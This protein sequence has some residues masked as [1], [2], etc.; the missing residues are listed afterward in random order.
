MYLEEGLFGFI[1]IDAVYIT[2]AFLILFIL[3]YAIFSLMIFRQIQIMAKTLPTSLSPWLKFIGIVQIGISL[4]L[5]FVVIG[6]F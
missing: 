6:A 1:E 5:L 3:F 2:K 4:G